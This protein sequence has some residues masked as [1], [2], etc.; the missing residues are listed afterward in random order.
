MDLVAPS[1]MY[2]EGTFGAFLKAAV[3]HADASTEPSPRTETHPREAAPKIKP[4]TIERPHTS[5]YV[6]RLRRRP[7]IGFLVAVS[8]GVIGI[9]SVTDALTKIRA[10]L[11]RVLEAL[12]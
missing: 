2:R 6:A 5:D 7:V 11:S 4:A 10:F 9:A 12:F 3:G 8:A 1:A